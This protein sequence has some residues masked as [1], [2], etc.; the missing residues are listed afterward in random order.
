MTSSSGPQ[1]IPYV[2]V[3]PSSI[4]GQTPGVMAHAPIPF[5]T[6]D[7]QAPS[8]AYWA[9]LHAPSNPNP[10]A[11]P[12]PNAASY[13]APLG[14]AT[15]PDVFA[16]FGVD[17]PASSALCDNCKADKR[18]AKHA[19]KIRPLLRFERDPSEHWLPNQLAH[20][21]GW[22][23]PAPIEHHC[24][25]IFSSIDFFFMVVPGDVERLPGT[26]I[27]LLGQASRN[28]HPDRR[29]VAMMDE[30]RH[31]AF[32]L[33]HLKDQDLPFIDPPYGLPGSHWNLMDEF[34][35][36]PHGIPYTIGVDRSG[37]MDYWDTATYLW[38]KSITNTKDAH[39]QD[40][41]LT[42]FSHN[43]IALAYIW[44]EMIVPAGI[45]TTPHS[46]F[47][48]P[49]RVPYYAAFNI[50]GG[51]IDPVD[52]LARFIVFL[53]EVARF[54]VTDTSVV[55][56]V[57]EWANHFIA[58]IARSDEARVPVD[59]SARAMKVEESHRGKPWYPSDGNYPD[60]VP[61]LRTY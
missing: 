61:P 20:E 53:V 33:V 55:S 39:L 11:A 13:P 16:R 3:I 42:L 18:V 30:A 44:N 37:Q 6:G 1:A 40:M 41:L 36:N 23:L 7:P 5:P 59:N 32:S 22:D 15:K 4:N 45:P 29:T 46:P 52:E 54:P 26:D 12:P 50:G 25:S 19:T 38:V 10:I 2:L 43:A 28:T 9:P 24:D 31:H 34:T 60:T 8:G 47:P 49:F 51:D 17:K 21:L 57:C 27:T 56:H 14:S 48:W 58:G 35:K